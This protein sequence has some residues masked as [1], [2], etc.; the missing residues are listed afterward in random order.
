MKTKKHDPLSGKVL[1][2]PTGTVFTVYSRRSNCPKR[3]LYTGKD[4]HKALS[5]F[6]T[7]KVFS[8]D[9]KYLVYHDGH[10]EHIIYRTAGEGKRAS[11][12]G[13][14]SGANYHKKR[15]QIESIPLHLWEVFNKAA[16]EL[17][18]DSGLAMTASSV[19]PYMMAHF[20]CLNL[21]DRQA[22]IK[23]YDSEL[24]QQIILSGGDNT[25]KI[26]EYLTENLD[27]EL[28]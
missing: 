28:L 13:R 27:D 24:M 17:T 21:E 3:V 19:L 23:K 20:Y 14:R 9:Y 7:F 6:H 26:K 25:K 18:D 4:I 1:D 12:Q 5:T 22:L 11:Y 16:R 8:Q 15:V 2:F 10:L